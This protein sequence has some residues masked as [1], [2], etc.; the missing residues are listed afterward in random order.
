MKKFKKI[1]KVVLIT[2]LVLII[3]GAGGFYLY[4]QDYY[5]AVETEL[6]QTGDVSVENNDEYVK[7][8]STIIP[9]Q[10]QT[11]IIFYPGAKVEPTAYIPLMSDLAKLGYTCYIVK[12]PFNLA[13]LDQNAADKIIDNN[14]DIASWYLMGHSMGG[15]TASMYAQNHNDKIK[16]LILLAAY[17]YGDY[18]H[19]KTLILYGSNDQ[20]LT[21]KETPADNVIVIEGGNHAQFGNYGKQDGDGEATIPSYEQQAITAE[22]IN[23]FIN[24]MNQ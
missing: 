3:L 10:P 23:N 2:L 6:V 1:L 11:G 17:Y 9:E 20:V 4:T 12:M 8:S 16:G 15:A 5:H 24:N 22:A 19:D 7:V 21:T 18:P 13:I 14:T